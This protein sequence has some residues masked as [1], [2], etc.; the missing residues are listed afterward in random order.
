MTIKRNLQRNNAP[1]ASVQS[2]SSGLE[3]GM[4]LRVILPAGR[5]GPCRAAQRHAQGA[6]RCQRE[7]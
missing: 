3:M 6:A 7:V 1:S 4:S 2:V 5:S